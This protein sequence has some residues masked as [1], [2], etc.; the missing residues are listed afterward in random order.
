MLSTVVTPLSSWHSASLGVP[1]MSSRPILE[2]IVYLPAA[3]VSRFTTTVELAGWTGAPS[4][5]RAA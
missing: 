5:R 1:D 2:T 4:V 3:R